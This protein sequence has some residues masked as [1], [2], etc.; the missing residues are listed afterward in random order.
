MILFR[1][2]ECFT[3]DHSFIHVER[4]RHLADE[5]IELK[6]ILLREKYSEHLIQ[7]VMLPVKCRRIILPLQRAKKIVQCRL[8]L[9]YRF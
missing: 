9:R 2:G 8:R 1:K 7:N 6:R 4:H 3:S 5:R